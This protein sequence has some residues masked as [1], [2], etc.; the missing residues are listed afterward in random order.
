MVGIAVAALELGP[1]CA[2][3]GGALVP[4]DCASGFPVQVKLR[5]ETDT[6][7]VVAVREL[8]L[9]FEG[10][11]GANSNPVIEGSRRSSLGIGP[12]WA[13]APN[14]CYRET[15]RPPRGPA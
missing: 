14:S 4:V 13:M 1:L 10:E 5:V 6:D 12:G 3:T 7:V 8:R 9:R 2:G 15:G 11:R